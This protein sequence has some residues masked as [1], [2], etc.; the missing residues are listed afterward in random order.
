MSTSYKKPEI[1][2]VELKPEERLAT[3]L[4]CPGRG[5]GTPGG[6]ESNDPDSYLKPAC[7]HNTKKS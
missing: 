1:D 4:K 5:S 6:N 7:I 2:F 3:C